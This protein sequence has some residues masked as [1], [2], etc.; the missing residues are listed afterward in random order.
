MMM[1]LKLGKPSR[2]SIKCC[3]A[4]LCY[5]PADVQNGA[6]DDTANEPFEMSKRIHDT[7]KWILAIVLKF[8]LI[9][10]IWILDCHHS[11]GLIPRTSEHALAKV[12]S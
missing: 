3:S 5:G 2:Y 9:R 7:S 8:A 6:S 1:S 12:I 11:R 4:A 10:K